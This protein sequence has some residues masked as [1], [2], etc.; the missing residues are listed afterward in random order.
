[1]QGFIFKDFLEF[2]NKR[3]GNAVV[4]QA[5]AQCQL[6]SGGVYSTRQQYNPKELVTLLGELSRQTGHSTSELLQTYGEWL[7]RTL[8]N[9]PLPQTLFDDSFSFL[10]SVEE[11]FHKEIRELF[12]HANLPRLHCERLGPHEM[13]LE[14]QSPLALAD[15]AH[16][17]LQ[18]CF[19]HFQEQVSISPESL[20]PAGTH[21]RFHLKRT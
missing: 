2:A 5:M 3:L 20:G 15:L 17:L 4:D 13:T 8:V 18:G 6:Q 12:P 19:Q 9:L 7:F 11:G 10:A 14:Y 16:G 21:V 1:M